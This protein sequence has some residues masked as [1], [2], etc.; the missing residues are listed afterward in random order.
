MISKFFNL[1]KL[2]LFRFYKNIFLF[3]NSILNGSFFNNS[4]KDYF[5]LENSNIT[6]INNLIISE[7]K[8]ME[9][10][11]KCEIQN[12]KIE[13]KQY[14]FSIINNFSKNLLK[15]IE[16]ILKNKDLL[17]KISNCFGYKLKF[18]SF[19][20]KYNIFN[21]VSPEEYKAKMWHRDNDSLFGQI[22]FFLIINNLND[23]DGGFFYFIPQKYLP[24]YYKLYSDYMMDGDKFELDDQKSR[25]KNLDILEKYNL[26]QRIVKYGDNKKALLVDA[27]ETYHKGGYI[28]KKNSFRILLEVIYDPSILSLT[29][30]SPYYNSSF[31]YRNLKIFLT[32]LKNRLRINI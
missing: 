6:I 12:L 31:I 2:N 11:I 7:F 3:P 20:I 23:E 4:S 5:Y 27:N 24:S 16:E 26:D 22:K 21:S 32:G 9:D 15:N 1:V 28:K 8:E 25:I 29:N 30:Y 17:K 14:S 18:R 19:N 10:N 13:E